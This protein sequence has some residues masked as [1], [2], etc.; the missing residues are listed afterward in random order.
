MK[1][2]IIGAS[3]FIGQALVAEAV[4]KK[5]HVYA[6]SRNGYLAENDYVTNINHD[7]NDWEGLAAK[8]SDVDVIISTFKPSLNNENFY[9]DFIQGAHAINKL[10]KELETR[11]IIVGGAASLYDQTT[12]IQIYYSLDDNFKKVVRDAF[13][14]YEE[15]KN[16]HSFDWTFVS[17]AINL[18]KDNPKNDYNIGGDFVLYNQHETST[19]SIFDLSH[20]LVNIINYDNLKHK[21][22]TLS[23][24]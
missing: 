21:R 7:V 5:H 13:D 10:A 14:L 3:G 8:I 6:I 12:N 15:L 17:P 19:I 18:T 23:N 16:D 1:I 24:R 20:L 22:I 11:I 9:T 2:G 4:E